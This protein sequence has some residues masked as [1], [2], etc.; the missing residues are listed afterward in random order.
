MSDIIF[1]NGTF[2]DHR[3]AMI[4]INDRG[5]LIGDGLFETLRF[6]QLEH[7]FFER[8]WQRLLTGCEVLKIQPPIS[9]QKTLHTIQQ[10]LT[11]NCLD[12]KTAGVRITLSRGLG[13]RGLALPTKTKPTFI[14]QCFEIS[15]TPAAAISVSH[16]TQIINEHSPLRTFKSLSYT[17][18]LIARQQANEA[19]FDDALLYNTQGCLA[20]A[21][22]ANCFLVINK[23]LYTPPLS[24]GALPGITRQ[25]IIDIAPSQHLTVHVKNLT[26]KDTTMAEEAFLTNSIQPVRPIHHINQQAL[27]APG[28]LTQQLQIALQMI[29]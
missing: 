27:T 7:H 9:A 29:R 13:P 26:A 2:I 6:D 8:H 19:G 5:F 10:L 21:S 23:A 18:H 3:K 22:S 12:K 15:H 16:S 14:I 17:E 28:V 11:R 4:S 20:S 24:A 25:R 1:A